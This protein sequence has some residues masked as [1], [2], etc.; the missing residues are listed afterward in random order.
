MDVNVHAHPPY[1]LEIVSFP[2]QWLQDCNESRHRSSFRT[3]YIT[4]RQPFSRKSFNII[5]ER[6]LPL[7]NVEVR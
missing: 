7:L 2:V 4:W 1:F 3:A 5:P 6:S